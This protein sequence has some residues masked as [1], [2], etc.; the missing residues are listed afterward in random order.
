MGWRLDVGGFPL[1]Q[2]LGMEVMFLQIQEGGKEGSSSK[3]VIDSQRVVPMGL[4]MQWWC[5][6][7][8]EEFWMEVLLLWIYH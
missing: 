3:G 7:Y 5:L 1:L 4:G 6:L 8:S 2:L